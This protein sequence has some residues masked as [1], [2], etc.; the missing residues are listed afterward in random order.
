M[1][2]PP[3][4]SR[5]DEREAAFLAPP[6]SERNRGIFPLRD[7]VA[8]QTAV[9]NDV[10]GDEAD[11]SRV[12]RRRQLCGSHVVIELN[13]MYAGSSEETAQPGKPNMS[14]SACP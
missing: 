2:A 7:V 13:H 5:S 12:A 14:Q 6:E 1:R 8:E 9:V 10:A 4:L 3:G 11:V